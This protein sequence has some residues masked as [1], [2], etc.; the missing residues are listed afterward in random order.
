MI[1]KPA[2]TIVPIN[3]IIAQR[4]SARAFD[5]NKQVSKEQILALCEAARWAPSCSN[6]QPYRFLIFDKY[7]NDK[8]YNKVRESFDAGNTRWSRTV[9]VIICVLASDTFR[10]YKTHNRWAQFDT[11]AAAE[12]IYLQAVSMGL[13]AHPFGGFDI[14]KVKIDFNIPEEFTPMAMIAIGYQSE[15]L[16]VLD[17]DYMQK[18]LLERTRIPLDENFFISEWGQSII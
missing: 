14:D 4:W 18:E 6:D 10:K 9:P 7:T 8:A 16:S 5:I 12:N 2:L 13:I 3:D 11:G 1:E 17:E 15:D